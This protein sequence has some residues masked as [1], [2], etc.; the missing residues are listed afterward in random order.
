MS[1]TTVNQCNIQLSPT[2]DEGSLRNYFQSGTRGVS[3]GK[4]AQPS[5]ASWHQIQPPLGPKS[6]QEMTL[7]GNL[8]D[9][10]RRRTRETVFSRSEVPCPISLALTLF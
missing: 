9:E 3:A 1:Q 6:W 4:K 7:K 2:R 5:F 8:A 10:E